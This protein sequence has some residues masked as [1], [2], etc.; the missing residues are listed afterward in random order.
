MLRVV[1]RFVV[2]F[3]KWPPWL[4]DFI[5]EF[6]EEQLTFNIT[7]DDIKVPKSGALSVGEGVSARWQDESKLCSNLRSLILSGNQL[8]SPDHPESDVLQELVSTIARSFIEHLA[9]NRM[10]IGDYNAL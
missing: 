4:H 10:I 7:S 5:D 2:Q 9:L 8:E 1:R 6:N 3:T